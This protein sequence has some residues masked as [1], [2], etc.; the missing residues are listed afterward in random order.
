MYQSVVNHF[1]SLI[2]SVVGNHVKSNQLN[3]ASS[4]SELTKFRTK[5][6]QDSQVDLT[7]AEKLRALDGLNQNAKGIFLPGVQNMKHNVS[8]KV[9][10]VR[11]VAVVI[12]CI[13]MA[14]VSEVVYTHT[15][16]ICFM[17]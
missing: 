12:V 13:N 14:L 11:F 8:E 4:D 5:T 15:C 7:E 16:T 6:F 9:A 1:K 3:Q 2:L 10:Q 17:A